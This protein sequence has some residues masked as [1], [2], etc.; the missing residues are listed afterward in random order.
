M[1]KA[2]LFLAFVAL[3][4]CTPASK[5]RLAEPSSTPVRPFDPPPSQYGEICVIHPDPRGSSVTHVVRDNGKLVGATSGPSYF[6]YYAE[7]GEHEIADEGS[8]AVAARTVVEAKHHYYVHAE[9]NLGNDR[10]AWVSD[11]AARK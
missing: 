9:V 10:L 7:P 6:C 2:V 3:A 4:A 8:D 11:D 1:R 5:Y